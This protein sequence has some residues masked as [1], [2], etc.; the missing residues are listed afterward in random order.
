[1]KKLFNFFAAAVLLISLAACNN[2]PKE[3]YYKSIPDGFDAMCQRAIDE[4]K[5]P[6]MAVAVVKDG[7]VVFMKGYGNAVMGDSVTA[8]VPVTPQTQFVI[9]STSKAFTAG[10]LANVM[11][12]YPE[13]KWDAPVINYLPDFK[14]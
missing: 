1:M 10:L 9:A 8:P 4:W 12:E 3:K 2:N 13:I 5:V 11:D 14:M 6:G 7:E